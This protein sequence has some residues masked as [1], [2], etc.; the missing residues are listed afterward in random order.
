MSKGR[1]AI[2]TAIMLRGFDSHVLELLANSKWKFDS[3]AGRLT[4]H[5]VEDGQ[6]GLTDLLK[7]LYKELNLPTPEFPPEQGSIPGR[8][9]AYPVVFAENADTGI[10]P[11]LKS[12]PPPPTEAE[13][14][15][16]KKP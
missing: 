10:Q 11:T 7:G 14:A 3:V 16:W 13:T 4:S 8:T 6:I 15:E 12:I 1:K 9:A 5:F 2:Q